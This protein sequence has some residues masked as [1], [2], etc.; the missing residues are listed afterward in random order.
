LAQT[1]TKCSKFG[2]VLSDSELAQ[3]GLEGGP[4]R[5]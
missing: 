5:Y 4:S 1:L 2:G 3:P